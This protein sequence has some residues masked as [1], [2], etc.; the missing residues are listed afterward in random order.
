[1]AKVIS[2]I[3]RKKLSKDQK[4]QKNSKDQKKMHASTTQCLST[5]KIGWLYYSAWLT[6]HN[7]KIK[8]N[9]KKKMSTLTLVQLSFIVNQD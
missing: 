4:T 6:T 3:R 7:R 8:K 9:E 1:M 2:K 5:Q